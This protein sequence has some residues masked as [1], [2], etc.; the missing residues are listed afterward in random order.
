VRSWGWLS[1]SR[2]SKRYRY[3]VCLNALRHGPQACPARSV[4]AAVIE[5]FVVERIEE[6]AN[7]LP[8]WETLTAEE[9][10]GWVLRLVQRVEYDGAGSKVAITFHPASPPTQNGAAHPRKEKRR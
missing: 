6:F 3:Y 4:A 8:A 5:K 2:R 7:S 10:A 9:Q 1:H